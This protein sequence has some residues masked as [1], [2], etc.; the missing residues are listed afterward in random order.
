MY[1]DFQLNLNCAGKH[2]EIEINVAIQKSIKFDEFFDCF[3]G[4][5]VRRCLFWGFLKQLRGILASNVVFRIK[6][7]IMIKSTDKLMSHF[8]KKTFFPTVN[9]INF[10]DSFLC[11]PNFF[12]AVISTIK[13]YSFA[14]Q[15]HESMF[16]GV[17][18]SSINFRVDYYV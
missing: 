3:W 13:F 12:L 10:H 15:S 5:F 8:L 16:Q 2:N 6:F 7:W 11:F 4:M 1:F 14:Q 18:V 17:C 9:T